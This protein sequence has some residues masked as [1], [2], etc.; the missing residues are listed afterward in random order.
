MRLEEVGSKGCRLNSNI[1][2]EGFGNRVERVV[3]AFFLALVSGR[4][5]LLKFEDT[6]NILTLHLPNLLHHKHHQSTLPSSGIRLELS[7]R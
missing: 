2:S 5:F 1:L 7:P 4:A 3:W 6:Y